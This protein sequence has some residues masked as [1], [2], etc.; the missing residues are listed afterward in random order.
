MIGI[1]LLVA[2]IFTAG[3]LAGE[4]YLWASLALFMVTFFVAATAR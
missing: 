3:I 2:A 1:I 4:G